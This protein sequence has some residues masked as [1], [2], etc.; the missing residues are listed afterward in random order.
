MLIDF[1]KNIFLKNVDIECDNNDSEVE[2]DD[3]DCRKCIH[4]EEGYSVVE[5]PANCGKQTQKERVCKLKNERI[6]CYYRSLC[7][8]FE[9][10]VIKD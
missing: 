5:L 4:H 2:E 8:S 1:I 9:R 10:N 6:Q 7:D 3:K